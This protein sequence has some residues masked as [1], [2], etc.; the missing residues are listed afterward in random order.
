MR[1]IRGLR[2]PPLRDMPLSRPS[3][4]DRKRRRYFLPSTVTVARPGEVEETEKR[5]MRGEVVE[6]SLG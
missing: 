6:V 3:L 1:E 2:N 5:A 4:D